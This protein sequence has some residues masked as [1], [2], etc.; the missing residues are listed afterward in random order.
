MSSRIY[1]PYC[2]CRVH[3][4]IRYEYVVWNGEEITI[5][6]VH[7]PYCDAEL[8]ENGDEDDEDDSGV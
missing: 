8:S 5:R 2:E 7:C 3:P 6:F 1:C 4:V